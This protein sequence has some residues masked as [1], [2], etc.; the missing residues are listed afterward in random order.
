MG[1]DDSAA[2]LRRRAGVLRDAARRA[3]NA[4]AG[5]GTYLDGPVKKASATGKD[6]I[7]KG[8][9]AES[10]TKTLSSRSSTLHTMAADLLAD[11]KRWVTEAGRLEDRAKDADKKGGH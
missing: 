11:A 6:Q 2:E 7:W 5:L 3:R 9:W 1:D 8:P 4:A 10:T